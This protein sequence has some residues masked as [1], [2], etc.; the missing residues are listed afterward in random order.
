LVSDPPARSTARANGRRV[1]F[2]PERDTEESGATGAGIAML[3]AP[4]DGGSILRDV[5]ALLR[6]LWAVLDGDSRDCAPLIV[7]GGAV[8]V[9]GQERQRLN[10]V[11]I[12]LAAVA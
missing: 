4:D 3:N 12:R 2:G 6:S 8:G 9:C 10:I 7:R 1:G 5:I 11:G